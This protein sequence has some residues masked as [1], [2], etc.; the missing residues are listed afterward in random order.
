MPSRSGWASRKGLGAEVALVHVVD[1]KLAVAPDMGVSAATLMAEAR[2]D[3][4]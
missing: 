4:R 3:G 2:R 1:P